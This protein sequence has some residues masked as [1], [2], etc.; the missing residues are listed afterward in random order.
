MNCDNFRPEAIPDDL[1]IRRKLIASYDGKYIVVQV[2]DSSYIGGG[3]VYYD[4]VNGSTFKLKGDKGEHQ[5]KFSALTGM[6]IGEVN[7]R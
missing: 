4:L 7:L 5:I 3:K 2:A 6:L 1:E